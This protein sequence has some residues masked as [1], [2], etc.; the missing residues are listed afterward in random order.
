MSRLHDVEVDISGCAHQQEVRD[1]ISGQL[2]SLSG[3]V[4]V[5]LSGDLAQDLDLRLPNLGADF[6]H[7]DGL[8]LR[9]GQVFAAY[10]L[11][12]LKNE[13]T[14]R[15]QFVQDVLES[16]D[17]SDE[18]RQKILAMGLRALEGRDDLGIAL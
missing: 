4:R 6:S 1:L 16:T 13:P 8:Q 12:F 11:D 9:T 7:L 3:F 5:T 2:S 14:V 15:G 18:D 10:D 17:L